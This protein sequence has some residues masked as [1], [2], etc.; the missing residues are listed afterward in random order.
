MHEH[1]ELQTVV[2][3]VVQRVRRRGSER[4]DEGAQVRQD[5]GRVPDGLG[6][7]LESYPLKKGRLV[8][9]NTREDDLLF[10]LWQ[11]EKEGS[12]KLGAKAWGGR[13]SP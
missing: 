5:V 1:G 7:Q 3:G 8:L 12:K 4:L 13:D 11:A 10:R 6:P 9:L 2:V